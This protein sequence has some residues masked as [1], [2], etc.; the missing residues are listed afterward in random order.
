MLKGL[1]QQG[2]TSAVYGVLI[3]ATVVVFVVQFRPGAQGKAASIRQQCVAE[4]RGRCLEPKE[5]QAELMLTAPGRMVEAAQLKALGIR[6]LVLDGLVERTLLVQDAERLGLSVSENE[7]NDELVAGRARVSL[8]VERARM[9]G[10]ALQLGDDGLRVLPVT[11]P[12]T[13]AFDYKVYDKVVRQFSNRSPTE[14]KVMQ[15]EE[16]LASRMR[17]LI[18]SRVRVGEDE[19]FMTYQRE[20]STAIIRF[21]SFKRSWFAHHALDLSNAAIDAWAKDHKEEIDR[22]FETRKSQ[23]LP[24]CR[25]AR[26]ILVKVPEGASDEKKAEASKKIEAALERVKKGEDFA[27]VA[28]EESDDTS[29][30]EGGDLGCFQR[31][32]MVKPFEDAA[33]ALSPGQISSVVQ[34]QFGFHVIKL[35]AVYKD[36]EAEAFGRR[37]TAKTLMVNHEAEAL[38]AETAKKVLAAVKAGTKFDAAVAAALPAEKGKASDKGKAAEKAE[39]G[40]VAADRPRVEISGSFNSTADP[41]PGVASGQS[42]AELAFKLEK[43]G[44][45]P[46][47]LVKLDDGYAVIQLKE[48]APATKEAFDKE[49]DTFVSAML[50]AKQADAL[51]GYV[52]RLRDSAKAETKLDEAYAKAPEKEK[53]P[54]GEEE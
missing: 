23:F 33:Y 8:P 36:A 6:R 39:D 28:R 9:L 35:D 46:D 34:S 21:A 19:A 51:N 29:A 4:V 16:L 25:S 11:N 1:R 10:Y 38:A 50:A 7:L 53:A 20:K 22:V 54:E 5:Y 45:A 32:R 31:G 40:R 24:E 43:E 42:V 18:R 48:K 14:F 47:D 17:D 44:D 3:V 26:H 49:R 30:A 37:D 2:F 27:K 13:K 52:M 41:V 15:R 12:E